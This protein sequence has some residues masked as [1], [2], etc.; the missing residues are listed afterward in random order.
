MRAL[1]L[2]LALGATPSLAWALSAEEKTSRECEKVYAKLCKSVPKSETQLFACSQ[3]F[4]D[5]KIPE[6]CQ[7][8]YQQKFEGIVDAKTAGCV[9]A[10]QPICKG[11]DATLEGAAFLTACGKKNAGLFKNLE[12]ICKALAGS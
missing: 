2:I 6:K 4:P 1:V 8:D 11:I 3:K 9:S 10:A 12:P 7:G 5:L